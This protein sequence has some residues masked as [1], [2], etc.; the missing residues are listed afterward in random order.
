M[1]DLNVDSWLQQIAEQIKRI[2]GDE[3]QELFAKRV[4]VSRKTLS[5]IENAKSYNVRALLKILSV[6]NSEATLKS[7]LQGDSLDREIHQRLAEILSEAPSDAV[8]WITGN[9]KTFHQAYVRKR[10]P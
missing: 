8:D 2:R 10:R 1:A 3:K 5:N 4:K 9:I 6:T 7:I